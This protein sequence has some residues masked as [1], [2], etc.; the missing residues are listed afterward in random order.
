MLLRLNTWYRSREGQH[1]TKQIK[2]LDVL[3]NLGQVGLPPCAS[4]CLLTL[5]KSLLVGLFSAVSVQHLPL[6]GSHLIV[7]CR[8]GLHCVL[9]SNNYGHSNLIQEPRDQHHRRKQ[10]GYPGL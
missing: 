6:Q 9:K 1:G 3:G 5:Q 7:P 2:E 8:E 4:A 10:R